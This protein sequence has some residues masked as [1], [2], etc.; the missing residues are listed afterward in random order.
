MIF[1]LLLLSSTSKLTSRPI[2]YT[3][4]NMESNIQNNL[5]I[6]RK[7]RSL[8]Q[9]DLA[10]ALGISRQ[11]VIALEHGKYMPSL[12]LV[13]SICDFFDTAFEDLFEFER[14]IRNEFGNMAIP[15]SQNSDNNSKIKL[16]NDQNRINNKHSDVSVGVDPS[17]GGLGAVP[18][19]SLRA[20]KEAN[21]PF[22]LEPWRPFREAVSLRDAMDRLF[23]ESVVTP[24]KSAIA[25]P[26]IDIKEKKDAVV[27]KAEIPGVAEEDVEVEITDSVMTISG[28]KKEEKEEDKDGYHYKESHTGSFSRSFS[29]PSE[30]AAEKADAEMKNGVLIITVPKVEA[31]K[32]KK[33]MIK[34]KVK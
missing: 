3:R 16:I 7:E 8:S 4:H 21:M 24:V 15:L 28:E 22:E 5:K 14:E 27:V 17:I 6:F 11:S 9:E 10:E 12:P 18:S 25:I 34:K 19:T 31:K 32:P 30:V 1:V 23:E 13:V 29:L 26:K 20:G 33:V 2:N